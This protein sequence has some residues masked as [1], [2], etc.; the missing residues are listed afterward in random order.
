VYFEEKL[1]QG[2]EERIRREKMSRHFGERRHRRDR[3]C[4]ALA[5]AVRVSIFGAAAATAVALFRRF[6]SLVHNFVGL[7][8]IPE[9]ENDEDSESDRAG[10]LAELRVARLYVSF[11]KLFQSL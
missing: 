3:R 2:C 10:R 7:S 9:L 1:E 11:F 4:G 6:R 5:V 8:F